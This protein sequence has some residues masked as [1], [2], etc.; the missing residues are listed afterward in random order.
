MIIHLVSSMRQFN[1][2]IIPVRRIAKIIEINGD[3]VAFNWYD[4]V[5]A[6]R[7]VNKISEDSFDWGEIVE[8][9]IHAI[10]QADAL[11]LE[12]SR[13]NYSQGF[14]TAI[15]LQQDKPVLNLYRKDLSEYKEW[16]DKLFVSGITHP[17]FSNKAYST[18]Q[19]LEKIVETFL[20][21]FSKRNQEIN[22]KFS[23]DINTYQKLQK[24]VDESRR[25]EASTIKDI[26]S[27]VL[28]EQ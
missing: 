8:S 15:A 24:L 16:P 19:E 23:L 10:T 20:Q 12:G 6:R 18:E 4:G 17:L 3:S 11:I 5:D 7:Q 9:N 26:L 13:F 25:S 28:N 1:E 27:K 14:Q 21:K 22:P 2:D